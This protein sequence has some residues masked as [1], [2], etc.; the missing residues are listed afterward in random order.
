MGARAA[1]RLGP[2]F[3]FGPGAPW[4]RDPG[5][6]LGARNLDF[7]PATRDL[8]AGGGRGGVGGFPSGSQPGSPPGASLGAARGGGEA[9][10]RAGGRRIRNPRAVSAPWRGLAR[11]PVLGGGCRSPDCGCGG[12]A[13]LLRCAE[14]ETEAQREAGACHAPPPTPQQRGQK[15]PETGPPGGGS[16]LFPPGRI[17]LGSFGNRPIPFPFLLVDNGA[18]CFLPSLPQPPPHTTGGPE[19]AGT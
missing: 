19:R 18:L 7:L 4:P 17:S 10:R 12:L 2:G 16:A 9:G 5:N 15:G 8:K 14:R 11:R 1:F 3:E 13:G 6:C